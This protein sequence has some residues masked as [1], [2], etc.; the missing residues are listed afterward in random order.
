VG[1]QDEAKR[2]GFLESE[3]GMSLQQVSDVMQACGDPLDYI[4]F[5]GDPKALPF[6]IPRDKLGNPVSLETQGEI[7]AKA[8]KK[9]T[10]IL[11]RIAIVA[12]FAWYFLRG[13]SC[14]FINFE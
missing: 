9:L 3:D 1:S 5:R 2:F 7:S 13:T 14:W 10:W 8:L 6:N 4:D 11:I 12:T